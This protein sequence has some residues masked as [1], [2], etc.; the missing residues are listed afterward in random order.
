[1][2]DSRESKN[3]P[4]ARARASALGSLAMR[5]HSS[6]ELYQKLLNK[7]HPESIVV[8]LIADLQTSGLLSDIRFAE[9]YWR[10]RSSRGYGPIRIKQELRQRGVSKQLIDQTLITADLNFESLICLFYEKKY[11]GKPWRDLKEKA[12]RQNFLYRR[13]FSHDLIRLV[14]E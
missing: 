3:S 1:M 4:E 6:S 8:A 2:T 12:K 11:C 7:S 10:M 9:S 5:E 13:G 14:I